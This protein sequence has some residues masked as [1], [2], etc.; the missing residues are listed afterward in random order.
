MVAAQVKVKCRGVANL[1]YA[2]LHLHLVSTPQHEVQVG[3]LIPEAVVLYLDQ[4]AFLGDGVTHAPSIDFPVSLTL[5]SV[6]LQHDVIGCKRWHN[7]QLH[8]I[9]P[10]TAKEHGKPVRQVHRLISW[11]ELSILCPR[12]IARQHRS[13]PLESS[14]LERQNEGSICG[15]GLRKDAHL[16]M[17][18]LKVL[19]LTLPVN[20]LLNDPITN[21]LR[22]SP[23]HKETA[24]GGCATPHE[25]QLRYALVWREAGEERTHN[26]VHNVEHA[27]MVA[28]NDRWLSFASKGYSLLTVRLVGVWCHPGIDLLLQL[29]LGRAKILL[30]KVDCL[31][32]DI[33]RRRMGEEGQQRYDS[34]SKLVKES[35]TSTPCADNW[36]ATP[37]TNHEDLGDN[38]SNEKDYEHDEESGDEK[39]ESTRVE[40]V[41]VPILGIPSPVARIDLVQV[42]IWISESS[43]RVVGVLKADQAN[44]SIDYEDNLP[45]L[46]ALPTAVISPRLIYLWLLLQWLFKLA[47]R[48]HFCVVI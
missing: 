23:L 45:P 18:R 30:I 48:H 5:V 37:V 20:N 9:E 4:G 25:E 16:S 40:L 17:L 46:D 31:R 29:L 43:Q 6:F 2:A 15:C 28:H 42:C 41:L 24:K 11:I 19:N 8:R 7:V 27:N 26:H 35:E 1:E 22:S 3:I 44:E 21:L 14:P 33:L 34:D 36:L 10:N 39:K 12:Q 38:N 47:I 13:H 32:G